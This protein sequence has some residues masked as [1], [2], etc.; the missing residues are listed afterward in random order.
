MTIIDR[1]SPYKRGKSD[2]LTYKRSNAGISL[3]CG[4][5]PLNAVG[6]LASTMAVG[7]RGIHGNGPCCYADN[8]CAMDTGASCKKWAGSLTRMSCYRVMHNPTLFTTSIF[9]IHKYPSDATR[10]K[11]LQAEK[12]SMFLDVSIMVGFGHGCYKAFH[13]QSRH[14]AIYLILFCKYLTSVI[15]WI[16]FPFHDYHRYIPVKCP[17]G[18][19]SLVLNSTAL[20]E[21]RKLYARPHRWTYCMCIA[22]C[23]G[24]ATSW[25]IYRYG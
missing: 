7:G 12:V 24:L 9:R 16:L 14:N 13:L 3:Y 20:L 10:W 19:S 11:N 2:K 25:E 22:R 17:P 15:F 5:E 1:K 6:F 18:Y 4:A 21:S 23:G 8:A